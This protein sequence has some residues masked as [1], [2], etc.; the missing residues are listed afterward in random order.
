MEQTLRETHE[1]HNVIYAQHKDTQLAVLSAQP[2]AL[3]RQG[4]CYTSGRTWQEPEIDHFPRS[5]FFIVSSI[6]MG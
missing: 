4:G 5:V 6:G 1:R 2:S 3:N